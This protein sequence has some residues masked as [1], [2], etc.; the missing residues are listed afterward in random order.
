[1][2]NRTKIK[3]IPNKSRNGN[4]AK[5]TKIIDKNQRTA[6]TAL[7]VCSFFKSAKKWGG[8]KKGFS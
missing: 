6:K 7:V 2:D 5:N 4:K 1:V 8:K 3:G